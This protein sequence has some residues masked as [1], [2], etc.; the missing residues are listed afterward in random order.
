ME[1]EYLGVKGASEYLGISKNSF[2][3]HIDG[4]LPIY[5]IGKRKKYKKS[6]LDRFMERSKDG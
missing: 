2:Y 4:K 6:E 1:A 3:R 5:V